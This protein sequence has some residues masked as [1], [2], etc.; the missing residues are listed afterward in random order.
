MVIL[1]TSRTAQAALPPCTEN[2]DT[3]ALAT[4][5][6]PLFE[7]VALQLAAALSARAIELCHADPEHAARLAHVALSVDAKMVKITLQDS[8]TNKRIERVLDVA[9]L[10]EDSWALAI[11]ASTDELLRASWVEL[12][13]SD[14]PPPVAPPTAAVLRAVHSTQKPRARLRNREY[15]L[16]AA[17]SVL[18]ERIGLGGKLRVEQW[19]TPRVGALLA[20]GFG[21]GLR[22]AS[23]HGSVRADTLELE[24]GV[25]FALPLSLAPFGLS[26]EVSASMLRM[27]FV[28]SARAEAIA[29]S[30]SDYAAQVNARARGFV[31]AGVLRFSL[32]VGATYGIRPTRAFD[33]TRVVTG[34]QGVGV[35][36][37]S[38]IGVMP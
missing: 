27:S 25:A 11:A 28:A 24:A 9:P 3:V 13:L 6:S 1:H 32:S 30:F 34:N 5:A 17:A 16:Q 7:R 19:V 20:L 26:I 38:A 33:D 29:E 23:E 10:P 2:T 22:R 14:A 4:D 31:D 18:P 21:R 8:V 37:L 12:E 36:V 35:E 15:S